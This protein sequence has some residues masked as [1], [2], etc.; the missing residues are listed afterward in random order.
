MTTMNDYQPTTETEKRQD[1]DARSE[2]DWWAEHRR[3]APNLH[4]VIDAVQARLDE[5]PAPKTRDHLEAFM[6]ALSQF[7]RQRYELSESDRDEQLRRVA[8]L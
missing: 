6:V 7:Q 4:A 1:S 8:A 3:C 2:A 5:C